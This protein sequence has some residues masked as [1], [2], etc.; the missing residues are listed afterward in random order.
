MWLIVGLGNPGPK[1][2][3]TR[4]NVGFMAVDHC[5]SVLKA[6][7]EKSEH[8]ALTSTALF[9]G[10]KLLF[11][12]PQTFM[13]LSGD[14]VQAL[15]HFYKIPPER[16]LVLHDEIEQPFKQLKIQTK[17]GHG[18]HNGIRDIHLKMNT[19]AYFRIRIGVGRPNGKMDV[20]DYVLAPFTK[21]EFAELTTVFDLIVQGVESLIFQGYEKTATLLNR[22]LA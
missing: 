16:I 18:G 11:A 7:S 9:K 14:S 10:E 8:K 19:D 6:S 12:K 2:Q 22:K 5:A 13:N 20:A 15:S 4:H 3:S 21:S 1:Y 17:R